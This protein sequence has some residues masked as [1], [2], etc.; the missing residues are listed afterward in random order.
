MPIFSHY[1]VLQFKIFKEMV[2]YASQLTTFQ[3][4]IMT[5][6]LLTC[7]GKEKS[8]FPFYFLTL[9]HTQQT[10]LMDKPSFENMKGHFVITEF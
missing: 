7:I 8:S 1:Q 2:I 9:S 6:S 4:F 3:M 10:Y 5:R